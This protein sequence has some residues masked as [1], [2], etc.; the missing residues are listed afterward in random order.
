L[1]SFRVTKRRLA[2]A[3]S[4]EMRPAIRKRL[5]ALMAIMQGKAT[6]RAAQAAGAGVSSIDRWLELVSILQPI[7]MDEICALF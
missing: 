1:K 2:K 7:P 4:Q 5:I 6:A 3:L